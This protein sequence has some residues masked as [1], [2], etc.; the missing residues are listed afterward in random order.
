[1][2][3]KSAGVETNQDVLGAPLDGANGLAANRG[4]EVSDD[5]PAQAPLANDDVEHAPLEQ[6]GRDAAFRRFYFRELGR[7]KARATKTT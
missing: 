3:Y 4:F 6:S 2:Q 5:G 1:M 7:V